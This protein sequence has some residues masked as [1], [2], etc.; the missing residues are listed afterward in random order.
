MADPLRAIL[1]SG[2]ALLLAVACGGP[3]DLPE[4][5]EQTATE[6]VLVQ[7]CKFDGDCSFSKFGRYCVEGTCCNTP[8]D[9]P[10]HSCRAGS[11][12]SG[13]GDG[14]C[15]PRKDGSKPSSPAYC[16]PDDLNDCGADGTCDGAGECRKAKPAGKTCGTAK[17]VCS[18]QANTFTQNEC[19]GAGACIIATTD[20]APGVCTPLGGCTTQCSTPDQCATKVCTNKA[21]KPALENGKPCT[22]GV[23]C[24]SGSCVDGVC[25][26]SDCDKICGSCLGVHTGLENGVCGPIKIGKDPEDECEAA[27]PCGTDGQC[28]GNYA[29]RTMPAKVSC[30]ATQCQDGLISG[31][32]CNGLGSCDVVKE[33]SCAPYK[34]CKSPSACQDSC[35]NSVE[36]V[37]GYFCEGGKCNALKQNICDADETSVVGVEGVTSCN[38]FRCKAGGCLSSCADTATDCAAP[39]ICDEN[40][41]CALP[42]DPTGGDDSGCSVVAPAHPATPSA[43]AAWIFGAGALW[44]LR[45]RSLRA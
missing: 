13:G 15:G 1:V 17:P 7:A 19:D 20:C 3:G 24:E 2:T 12:A 41:L 36:C 21:C 42:R 33:V 37:D 34:S 25:C 14:T 43:P 6:V 40:A 28:D 26:D 10:C 31:S 32:A 30:G 16:V 45:R 29:C 11:K 23:Q 22:E 18:P 35:E 27:P 39:Y 44:L 9:N 8:C 38:G 5:A 4:P